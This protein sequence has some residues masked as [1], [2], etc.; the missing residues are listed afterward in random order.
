MK[1]I[2][3]VYDQ[4]FAKTNEGELEVFHRLQDE[5]RD[6]VVLHSLDIARPTKRM[7]AE[8]D[9]LIV[10][11]GQGVLALEVKG[12]KKFERRGGQWGHDGGTVGD[13]RDPFEQAEAG[14]YHLMGRLK[15][16]PGLSH[17]LVE[18]AVCFP[19]LT[20]R[21]QG[22][23]WRPSQVI[24]ELRLRQ[25]GSLAGCIEA[26]FRESRARVRGR[27]WFEES[28]PTLGQRDEIVE[29]E[30]DDFEVCQTA[31]QR[32]E[33]GDRE[34]RRYTTE[35]HHALDLMED[36]PRVVFNGPAGSGKTL[37]ALEA[38]RRSCAR[39]KNVLVLCFD[40]AQA[41]W[42]EDQGRAV[43]E[44]D[45]R[46]LVTY[47]SINFHMN[48]LAGEKPPPPYSDRDYWDRRLPEAAAYRLM[49]N[50][51]LVQSAGRSDPGLGIFDALIVDEAQDVFCE[52]YENVLEFSLL[53]GL[54]DGAWHMFGDFAGQ[55]IYGS[56]VSLDEMPS[57]YGCTVA[58]LGW[59]CRNTPSIARFAT[60]LAGDDR[61]Y[62][63]VRRADDDDGPVTKAW[64]TT[65]EQTGLLEESLEGL[66]RE[67]FRET[68]I[69]VLT[70]RSRIDEAAAADV[71][72][73]PWRG[74]L[75]ALDDPNILKPRRG[76]V[77][78]STVRRFRGLESR[79]VILT[80]VERFDD[81]SRTLLYVGAT[82]ATQRL[83]VLAHR[84]AAG[85][86]RDMCSGDRS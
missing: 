47:R 63:D 18:S 74:R 79:A 45:R 28:Q 33:R 61:L 48:E 64:Q 85:K 17:V 35:Q 43:A 42:L 84:S 15:Q 41:I 5:D 67:G 21:E 57:S 75:E 31:K 53:G 9:F 65:D 77:R 83:V 19:F 62:R 76:K 13:A 25:T 49:G 81:N 80:D 82:R 40:R 56:A 20:F 30:H 44:P 29:L 36:T 12:W 78:Y 26:V 51:D 68:D 4:R 66:W 58:R 10:A 46:P 6:W 14:K 7:K 37:L 34:I 11:P 72:R 52:R 50:R 38:A 23:G 86:I 22:E 69:V 32:A 27:A 71:W 70:V 1:L 55:S 60:Q 59:N 54:K 39:G 16:R 2:P 24:D 8:I 73:E 3:P